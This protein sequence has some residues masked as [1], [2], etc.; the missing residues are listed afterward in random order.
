MIENGKIAACFDFDKTLIEVSSSDLGFKWLRDHGMLPINFALKIGIAGLMYK[1]N[2]LSEQNMVKPLLSF[3]RGRYLKDFQETA[4]SFWEEIL[5][6]HLAPNVIE[7]LELHKR[8]NHILILISGSLHYL[9]VPVVKDLGFHHLICTHLE[10]K[11][12]GML[13][14][15]PNGL[16]CVAENKP[17]LLKELALKFNLDL[18]RSFA[19][20]DHH[21]DIPLL[22]SVG[23]PFAVEPTPRLKNIAGERDWPIITFR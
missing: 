20:S 21:S 15:R 8:N 12:N 23:Y 5:K 13:T 7:R 9:L 11:D 3:Y 1:N 22:E 10:V 2:I 18:A 4:I 19:Y 6:P 17:L 16:V 14:G